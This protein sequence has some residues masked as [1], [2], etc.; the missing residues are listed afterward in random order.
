M[1]PRTAG[2]DKDQLA[3]LLNPMGRA[4]VR[5]KEGDVPLGRQ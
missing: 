1:G 3:A 4:L 2:T 5:F